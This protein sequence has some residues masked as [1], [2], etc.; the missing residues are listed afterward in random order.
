MGITKVD[1]ELTQLE[2]E[3][4][5][6]KRE[7]AALVLNKGLVLYLIFMVVGV[8]GFAFD[9]IESSVLNFLVVA[10]VIILI[11]STLPYVFIVHKEERWIKMR[12]WELTK[13]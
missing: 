5:R 2:L 11:L 8:V 9:Y 12:I 7:K 10:G 3:R 6:I 4:S 1:S 13:K